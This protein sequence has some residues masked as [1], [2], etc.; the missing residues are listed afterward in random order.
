MTSSNIRLISESFSKYIFPGIHERN[1]YTCDIDEDC[2]N[3]LAVK[4]DYLP[5]DS[6][7][8]VCQ[9]RDGWLLDP[10]SRSCGNLMIV[11]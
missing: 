4:C 7:Y 3:R 6:Q 8:K 1:Y 10:V 2:G 5:Y 11:E 9:C